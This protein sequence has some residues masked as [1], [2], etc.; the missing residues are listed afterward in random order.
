M[1]GFT[2]GCVLSHEGLSQLAPQDW[3]V[4]FIDLAL[5]DGAV[6]SKLGIWSD[7]SAFQLELAEAVRS[8]FVTVTVERV[9]DDGTVDLA[10]D[11]QLQGKIN[12]P[13]RER[14]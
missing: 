2:E 13:L 3:D 5:R 14:V 11:G 4:N 8:G 1:E 10:L 12:A 9:R 7:A 6:H